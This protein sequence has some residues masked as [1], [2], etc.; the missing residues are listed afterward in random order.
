MTAVLMDRASDL[1]E[2]IGSVV[3]LR[4]PLGI[5]SVTVGIEPG[6]VSG[7]TPAWEIA[8]GNDFAQLRQSGALGP[9]SRKTLD[10][11]SAHVD[12]LLEPA[13]TGR[14]RALYVALGSGTTHELTLQ[15]A[16]PTDA[17]VGPVAH[18]IP[19]LEALGDGEPA[20]LVMASKDAVVVL[21]SELGRVNEVTASTSSPGSATGGPR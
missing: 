14:G 19:L 6:G 7:R 17:R 20:G 4:D 15:R 5:L 16:L 8:L 9:A 13:A 11:T 1:R 3:E 12:E 10:E 21:E 2:F 18:V